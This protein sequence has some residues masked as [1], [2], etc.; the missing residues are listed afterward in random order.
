MEIIEYIKREAVRDGDVIVDGRECASDKYD[1]IE[2]TFDPP[3]GG[4]YWL[5]IRELSKAVQKLDGYALEQCSIFSDND[6]RLCT[7]FIAEIPETDNG[8]FID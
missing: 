3:E 5:D 7:V 1:G 8:L 4:G 2:L 6:D